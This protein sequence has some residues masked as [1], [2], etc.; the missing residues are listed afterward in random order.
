MSDKRLYITDKQ[1]NALM[2]CTAREELCQMFFGVMLCMGIIGLYLAYKIHLG[3]AFGVAACWILAAKARYAAG[4][5]QKKH[6]EIL[7]EVRAQEKP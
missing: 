5:Y 3:A 7:D 2:F 6:D 4:V 1:L